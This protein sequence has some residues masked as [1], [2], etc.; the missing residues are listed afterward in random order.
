MLKSGEKGLKVSI[1]KKID[2]FSLEVDFQISQE[3][4]ALEG[5]SG[6]GKTMT[7]KC[8]AGIETP[9]EGLIVLNGRVLYDSKKGINIKP[10]QRNVGY[11]FQDYALFPNMSLQDNIKAG[12]GKHPD[13]IKLKEYIEKFKLKGLENKLPSQLSGGQK[14]RTA[15][16]RMFASNPE[17]F[18][19]DEPLAALDEELKKEL[20]YDMRQYLQDADR[21]VIFV[22]HNKNEI[23]S[24]CDR[25]GRIEN[26]EFKMSEFTHFDI[27]G[28]AVMVDVHEKQ[29]TYRIARAAGLIYVNQECYNAIKMGDVKKG[30]VLGVARIAGIMAAKKNAQLIP[31]CHILPLTKCS[32]EF[33]LLD[34]VCAVRAECTAA[35]VGKTGV[36]MEALTGVS[37]CLLTIYDMCK[38]IDKAM[39]IENIHLVEKDGGRSGHYVSRSEGDNEI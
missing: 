25:T 14:Q 1:K 20:I 18:L 34:E 2:D 12:M 9:D 22:S 26:G 37:V 29:D 35:C 3:I 39:R 15:M 30:D 33:E 32:I 7:L 38:A 4:L 27:N 13:E 17:I 24:I 6:V 19:M 31:L 11:M 5:V 28:N 36:E 16:A 23:N 21:P 8:I 10:Q